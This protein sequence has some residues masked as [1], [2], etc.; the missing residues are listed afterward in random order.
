MPAPTITTPVLRGCGFELR[1]QRAFCVPKRQDHHQS[2]VLRGCSVVC[3]RYRHS[4][5]LQTLSELAAV[6]SSL[7]SSLCDDQS[8]KWRSSVH[9]GPVFFIQSNQK[10]D[11]PDDLLDP[12][13]V[14]L[15]V[16]WKTSTSRAAQRLKDTQAREGARPTE[17]A[18]WVKRR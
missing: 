3:A 14:D 15:H 18:L 13:E 8:C 10:S 12:I 6:G 11:C 9:P 17:E 7:M 16:Y 4:R 2:T 5:S 1:E